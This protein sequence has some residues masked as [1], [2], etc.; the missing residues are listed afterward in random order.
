VKKVNFFICLFII[1]VFSIIDILGQDGS[2]DD[3]NKKINAFYGSLGF[4]GLGGTINV[5]YERL[6]KET[7]GFI[8]SWWIGVNP[9][10]ASYWEDNYSFLNVYGSAFK[11]IGNGYLEASAGMTTF[12]DWWTYNHREPDD[13]LLLAWTFPP[14]GYIGYRFNTSEWRFIHRIG[15]GFPAGI[16]VSSEIRF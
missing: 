12:L 10:L 4:Y 3:A 1:S 14:S 9:G 5:S 6:V 8:H 2:R 11:K 15:V 16:S 13:P 7:N